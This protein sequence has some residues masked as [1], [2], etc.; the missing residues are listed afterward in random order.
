[1]NLFYERYRDNCFVIWNGSKER[2][3]SFHHFLNSL[4]E[5]LK[6]TMKIAKGSLGLLNSFHQF[7]NSFRWRSQ[8]YNE[9]CERFFMFLRSENIYSRL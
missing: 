9:D 1:M 2:L 6:F 7:L 8:I 4:D 3:N 5:D